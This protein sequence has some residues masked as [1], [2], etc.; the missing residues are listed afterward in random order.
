MSVSLLDSF[1][2]NMIMNTLGIPGV[3]G[4]IRLKNTGDLDKHELGPIV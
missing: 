3:D 2:T 1:F 4:Q